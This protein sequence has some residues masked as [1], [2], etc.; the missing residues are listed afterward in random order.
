MKKTLF[1]VLSVAAFSLGLAGQDAKTP[2]LVLNH[3]GDA[4]YHGSQGSSNWAGLPP[5]AGTI[6]FYGGDVNPSDPNAQGFSNG[7]TLFTPK[8][9]T[10][11]AAKAP[12]NV[13]VSAIFYNQEPDI[14]AGTVF[15]P[16]TATY[17]IRTGV[18][19]GQAGT[20]IASGSGVQTAVATGRQPFG[21]IEYTTTVTFAKPLTATKGTT[22][23]VNESPQCTNTTN[24]NCGLLQYF[25]SNT[26]QETNSVNGQDQVPSQMYVN[27]GALGYTW[28]NWCNPALGQNA[29]QCA[30]ASWG[31]LK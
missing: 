23:W 17:D 29:Q 27:A 1:A 10:Y 7:N 5:A 28:L 24:T 3:G 4:A 8:W 19:E 16:A 11:A 30:R 15:D 21:L 14:T 18:S 22:Y 25:L 20:S 2:S 12:A 26:T 6:V 13:T 9:S 31:L